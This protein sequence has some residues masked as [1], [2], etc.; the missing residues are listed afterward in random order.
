MRTTEPVRKCRG[1]TEHRSRGFQPPV[2]LNRRYA[3][4]LFRAL[5]RGLKP[6]ATMMGRYATTRTGITVLDRTGTSGIVESSV[7]AYP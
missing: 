5:D 3:T 1:A 4:R 6:P 2:Y 7:D